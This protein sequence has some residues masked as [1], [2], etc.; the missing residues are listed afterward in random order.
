[1]GLYINTDFIVSFLGHYSFPC[2]HWEKL[3][4]WYTGH[5]CTILANSCDSIITKKQKVKNKYRKING[6]NIKRSS[7]HVDMLGSFTS[8]SSQ[9]T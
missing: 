1:M 7:H 8:L 4:E 3:D 5:L 6:K 2:K 9:I